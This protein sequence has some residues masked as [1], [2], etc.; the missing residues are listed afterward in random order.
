[1]YLNIDKISF[2][3]ENSEK[4][5][6]NNLSLKIE[7]EGIYII[8]GENGSG[9]STL[10]KI[11]AS[12]INIKPE[13]VMLNG[14]CVGQKMYKKMTG[15]IPDTPIL[16]DEL[17]GYEHMNIFMDLWDMGR[18]ER[19]AYVGRF[20][21]ISEK[22]SLDTFLTE[23]V[24]VL[25]YGT[26]YKLFFTLMLSRSPKLLLLDEPFT[27]LDIRSQ[28]TA[29]DYIK[30]Y[31]KGAIVIVSSHQREIINQL[32][33]NIYQLKNGALEEADNEEILENIYSN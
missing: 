14:V 15:Y 20:N 22:L 19:K 29:I 1:M 26:R 21:E 16:Y 7:K 10:L 25:S 8:E 12:I 28:H 24:R 18:E 30:E 33:K 31:G 5:I 13:K 11:L 27:S 2:S 3:Y 23:K 6:F 32:S 4:D 9:K 17:T